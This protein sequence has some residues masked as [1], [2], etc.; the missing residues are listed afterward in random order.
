MVDAVVLA[1]GRN[2]NLPNLGDAGYEALV[3]INGRAMG[4][5]VIEALLGS[6]YVNRVYV[7]AERDCHA[8]LRYGA[9]V[10]RLPC[11]STI[12]D[13]V[14]LAAR[15]ANLKGTLLLVTTDIPF[16][17]TAAI[18]E[19]CEQSRA[20]G[21]AVCYPIIERSVCLRQYPTARRTFVTLADGSFTGGNIFWLDPAIVPSCLELSRRITASR[22]K[23]WQ[24]AS[25]LGVKTLGLF[26][27]RRL[28]VAA[29][30]RRMSELTGSSCR[31]VRSREA[32][33]GMDID[34]ESDWQLAVKLLRSS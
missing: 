9:A 16:I 18:D 11:G 24:L 17:T 13:T 25:L 26:L 1:G 15:S 28:T 29:A 31:A 21:A 7:A 19:F 30:E 4:D 2:V 12:A 22:K 20:D 14:D 23:P 27:C 33:L 3:D 8:A 32:A 34:K 6:R 10:K 5:F